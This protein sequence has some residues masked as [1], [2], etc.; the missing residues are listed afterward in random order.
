VKK[1][2]RQIKRT[3]GDAVVD[4]LRQAFNKDQAEALGTGLWFH[5]TFEQ[6]W[7]T[8]LDNC[9]YCAAPPTTPY[10]TQDK[11][12]TLDRRDR[13][14]HFT[15]ENCIAVCRNCYSARRKVSGKIAARI[16]L[17]TAKETADREWSK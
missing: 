10:T 17:I 13:L 15:P 16:A 6:Y 11:R 2:K 1:A 4:G 12:S 7:S 3:S 5:L 14:K 9:F 8:I